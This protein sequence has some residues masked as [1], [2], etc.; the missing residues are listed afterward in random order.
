MSYFKRV[1]TGDGNRIFYDSV[2]RKDREKK[3]ADTTNI[4][5]GET[6]AQEDYALRVMEIQR[7][8]ILIFASIR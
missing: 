4:F 6:A 2:V 8:D 7:Y 1:M 3:K 5:N